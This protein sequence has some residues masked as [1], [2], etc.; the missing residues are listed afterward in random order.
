MLPGSQQGV[1]RITKFMMSALL[2]IIIV[3]AVRSVTLPGAGEGCGV[4][5]NRYFA[6]PHSVVFAA[7][8]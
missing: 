3:L 6:T 5:Q 2:L 1:E 4:L 7:M 8:G